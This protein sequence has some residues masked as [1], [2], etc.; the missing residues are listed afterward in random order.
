MNTHS[1]N[2]VFN[3]DFVAD[4][5]KQAGY[6]DE[7]QNQI[8]ELKLANAILD[9]IPFSVNEPFYNLVAQKCL[10]NCQQLLNDFCSLE[11]FLLVGDEDMIIAN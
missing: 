9:I 7:I 4:L 10:K 6:S 11:L 2:V 5:S 1:K 8:K 3:A